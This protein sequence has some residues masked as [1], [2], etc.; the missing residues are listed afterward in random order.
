MLSGYQN[1]DNP[2][3]LGVS[4]YVYK[5]KKVWTGKVV[6]WKFRLIILRC[7]QI[8]WIDFTEKFAPVAKTTI[9]RLMMA[10]ALVL[11]L[12]VHQLDVDIALLYADLDEEIWMAPTPDMDLPEGYG[13]RLLKSMYGLKQAPRNWNK[14]MKEF[15]LSLGFKQSILDKCLY[16]L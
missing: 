11:H 6:K 10:L 13:L 14:H 15:I 16:I 9:F 2:C 1:G 7:S 4:R 8:E 5:L 12:H 3:P